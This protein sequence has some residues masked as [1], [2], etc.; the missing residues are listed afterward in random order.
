[1]SAENQRWT[2]EKSREK[3]IE[4]NAN[5]SESD[6][7]EFGLD[8]E[9]ESDHNQHKISC[10]LGAKIIGDLFLSAKTIIESEIHGNIE[11]ETELIIENKAEIIGNIKG[12]EVVVIG[13]VFGKIYAAKRLVL[14]KGAFVKG[15]I[16]SKRLII[17]D[18]VVF[19][20][21]CDMECAQKAT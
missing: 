12:Q 21:F 6:F 7:S 20:G 11:S 3:R 10:I 19:E 15:D 18:G 9:R 4:K 1:M 13:N 16:C 17:E 8:L 14:K 5:A 2:I